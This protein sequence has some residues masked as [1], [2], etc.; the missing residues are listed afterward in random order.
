MSLKKNLYFGI[1]FLLGLALFTGIA[2]FATPFGCSPI[3]V[4][5]TEMGSQGFRVWSGPT[6]VSF[7][8]QDKKICIPSGF[9]AVGAE[10]SGSGWARFENDVT[11]VVILTEAFAEKNITFE[12]S[13]YVVRLLYP[14][15]MAEPELELYEATVRNSFEKMGS[16]YNDSI[17][18][19]RR[20]H[21][22]LVTVGVE[23]TDNAKT[24]IYP[25]PRENLSI[26][27]RSPTS[28]RGEELLIH[29][30]AH[31]YN[32][33]R[34]DTMAYQLYQSP[35]PPSDFQ[36]L[37]ASWSEIAFRSSPQGR[38]ARVAYLHNVHTAV[39]T[40]NFALITSGP[41]IRDKSEFENIERTV[42]VPEDASFLSAQYGHYI[43]GPLVM[44][45]IDGLLSEKNSDATV[46][47]ILLLVHT[48]NTSFLERLSEHLSP[49][50]ISDILS[51]ML[52]GKTVPSELIET[53]AKVY[54]IR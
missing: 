17:N 26:F 4:E 14:K 27:V 23:R 37:E 7:E 28:L 9:E 33:Q 41:F 49:K 35:I 10:S 42:I 20:T 21:T 44:V 40:K 30:V 46:E 1:C 54:D 36:E 5:E 32:R 51:W 29:A 43:L 25:D 15:H 45:A 52:E 34:T 16:L 3:S 47:K 39:Q 31:L 48:T 53:G 11:G 50:E 2:F 24:P 38:A 19:K 22:I 8:H 18:N 13:S 12:L 6:L